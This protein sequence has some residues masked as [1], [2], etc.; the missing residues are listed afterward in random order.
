MAAE[1]WKDGLASIDFKILKTW[2]VL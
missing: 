2:P 1:D